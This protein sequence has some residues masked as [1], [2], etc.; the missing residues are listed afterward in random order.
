MLLV[1]ISF[2]HNGFDQLWVAYSG[3]PLHQLCDSEGETEANGTGEQKFDQ[4]QVGFP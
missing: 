2:L 4:F 1:M 3:Q